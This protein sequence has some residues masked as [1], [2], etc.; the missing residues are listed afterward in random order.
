MILEKLKSIK[1]EVSTIEDVLN[2]IRLINRTQALI[3]K[4]YGDKN[5]YNEQLEDIRFHSSLKALL[6]TNKCKLKGLIDIII[7]DIELSYKKE[8]LVIKPLVE[9]EKIKELTDEIKILNNKIFVVHGHN[10]MMK[11]SVARVIEKLGLEP[12]ILHEQANKGM[13]VIE[14]FLSNSNVGFAVILLSSDDVGYSKKE[15]ATKAKDRARQNVIFELGF[16]TAKLGRERV[17]ALVENLSTFEI[18]S[19]IHGVIYIPFDGIDGTW[20]FLVAKELLNN[21]YKLDVAKIV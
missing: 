21:G 11:Q 17:I 15:G 13:T 20:K 14:K 18:P 5:S 12:I 10:E 8:E 3:F 7:D 6:D 9:E 1:T 19:D 2:F 4:Q 16:F